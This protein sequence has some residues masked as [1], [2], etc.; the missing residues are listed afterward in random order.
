MFVLTN[1]YTVKHGKSFYPEVA[2]KNNF[3]TF[4]EA[5]NEMNMQAEDVL[6]NDYSKKDFSIT[7]FKNG[8]CIKTIHECD[9]W[10][11]DEI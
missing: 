5:E 10:K 7:R 3:N 8:V 9:L 1:T 6:L 11:I 2:Y 4:S